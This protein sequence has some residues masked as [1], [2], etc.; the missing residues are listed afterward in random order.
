M[1][2]RHAATVTLTALLASLAVLALSPALAPAQSGVLGG[3][4]PRAG[5]NVVLYGA[6]PGAAKPAVL[7]STRSARG[8]GFSLRYRA[9]APRAVKYVLATRPGGGAEAGFPVPGSSYRLAAAIGAGRVPA[10]VVLNERT[11]VAM[12]YAMAQFIAGGR[13]AGKNPGLRNAAAM[14]T[15]LVRP[16]S[17]A[18][19]RV[20]TSF[21]NG[22]S[23]STE[24]TF[25]SLANLIAL[26]RA[27]SPRCVALLRLAS[28]PRGRPAG[29]TLAAVVAMARYPWHNVEPLFQLAQ[30][31][32][33]RYRP[34]LRPRKQPDAWTLALRF[35]GSPRTLDGPGAF[36]IDRQG[37]L[38]IG[39][40]YAYS[41]EAKKPACFG[42]ALLRF[43]PTGRTYPGSPYESGG[44]SG[45]GFGIGIDTRNH[46]WIGNFGFAG[47][48]CREEPPHNSVSEYLPNGKALS[49][50][51]TST[52]FAK[53]ANGELVETFKGGWEV[54]EIFW[55]QSTVSDVDNNIWVANCGNNSVTVI[56]DGKPG[57]AVNYPQPHLA[58]LGSGF[59]F[60]RPFGVATDA[61]GNAY[62]GGNESATVVKMAPDGRVLERFEG[63]G[64]HRPMGMATD[65]GGNVW[66]G[67]STWVVAPCVGQFSPEGGPS[68]GGSVTLIKSDGRIASKSPFR[69]GGLKNA[70]GVAVD[71]DDT[72]W[73]ANF[74][75]RRLSQ[76]CGTVTRNC[77]A[78]KRQTGAAISPER[79]GYWFDGLTR[80][81]G[82]AVDP[83]G[84]VW[85]VNNW[86][87]APIQSNPGGYQIVAYLGIAAPVKTPLIG[88]P[89][90]P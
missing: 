74:S 90:R 52:G 88:A 51:L 25:N 27:Q 67:N 39:N 22:N 87:N 32:R 12:G 10:R 71:G 3:S 58:P 62:V 2:A 6:K 13:V 54:G 65:S 72:V 49:P 89:E 40:N 53:N 46:V 81:T 42:R 9:A 83:S 44:A 57:S 45:V 17:G 15:N 28:V 55:P 1:P 30:L 59:G 86:K 16:R 23:T 4:V 38:W 82:L 41:R 84:N 20:L 26:C 7:G 56:P 18:P 50:D 69:G 85:L 21:P 68:E 37:S 14:T 77:P 64:L 66:V 70:W 43:T 33:E 73:V 48:G 24:R 61:A 35:E 31:G 76:L 47:S 78:G 8:G 5:M 79:R 19:S 63:G 36:A 34:A 29:D 60:S 75:G 11:T 80:V